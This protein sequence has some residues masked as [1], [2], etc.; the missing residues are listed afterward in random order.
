MLAAVDLSAL[1]NFFSSLIPSLSSVDPV[2]AG[3]GAVILFVIQILGGN[4]INVWGTIKTV[5]SKLAP[6]GLTPTPVV[7]SATSAVQAAIPS[8]LTPAEGTVLSKVLAGI[9][10]ARTDVAAQTGA[11]A[12]STLGTVMKDVLATLA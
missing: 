11:T 10:K 4:Q 6:V 7:T 2:A 9:Q 12:V 8:D 5:L 3:A 1:G